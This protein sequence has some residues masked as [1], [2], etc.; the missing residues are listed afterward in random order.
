MT[1]DAKYLVGITWNGNK[2][3]ETVDK[4]T[5]RKKITYEKVSRDLVPS[6]VLSC[7][8]TQE[9]KIC[10]VTTDGRKYFRDKLI[11]TGG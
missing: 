1:I 11:K 10:F 6:D 2:P 7:V 4:D 9:G 3:V 5:K 8:E